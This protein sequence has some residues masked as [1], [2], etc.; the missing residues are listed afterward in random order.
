MSWPGVGGYQLT[1]AFFSLPM[2]DARMTFSFESEDQMK[3]RYLLIC[4]RCPQLW[5]DHPGLGPTP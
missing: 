3:A 2:E 4:S 1:L 5:Q